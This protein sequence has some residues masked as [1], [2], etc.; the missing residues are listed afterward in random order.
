MSW[1]DGACVVDKRTGRIGR[2]TGRVG[3]R[4]RLRPLHGGR[5]WEC[6]PGSVR[7]ATEWEQRN[8]DVLDA[9]WRFWRPASPGA[10]GPVRFDH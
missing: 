10:P 4:L 9:S 6:P 1:A 7:A 8:A 3:T 2:V 5:A